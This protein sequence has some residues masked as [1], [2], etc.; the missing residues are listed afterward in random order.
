MATDDL[1]RLIGLTRRMAD[2]MKEITD[3]LV[4]MTK[5]GEEL[6]A[7]LAALERDDAKLVPFRQP[8]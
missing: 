7:R 4:E 3:I 5:H 8:E 6:E 2:H 1:D